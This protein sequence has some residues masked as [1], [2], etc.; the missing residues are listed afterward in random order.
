MPQLYLIRHGQASFGAKNYDVLSPLGE[1]QA[2]L[3]GQHLQ[4]CGVGF[5]QIIHGG[6]ERQRVTAENMAA[7]LNAAPSITV[8]PA[9]CE[10]DAMALFKSYLPAAMMRDERLKQAG[11]DIFK[12][13]ELFEVAFQHVTNSWLNAEDTNGNTDLEPWLD[14]TARVRN[15]LAEVAAGAERSD[16]IAIVSSGGPISVAVAEALELSAAQTIRLNWTTYNASCSEF[17][18]SSS[19]APRLMAYNNIDHLRLQQDP[20]FIT[21]R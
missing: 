15:G 10:Y 18:W 21:L 11:K 17:R 20:K 6:L 1:Q 16:R 13:R 7:G 9:F 5:E 3:L 8:N 19:R 12:N 2:S 4:A 14:F